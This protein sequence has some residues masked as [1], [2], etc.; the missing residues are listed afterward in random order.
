MN[1]KLT[2]ALDFLEEILAVEGETIQ[3]PART[4]QRHAQAILDYMRPRGV[5]LDRDPS[6]DVRSVTQKE[7]VRVVAEFLPDIQL[8]EHTDA[9]GTYP[10][11]I[12]A[13][14]KDKY[15]SAFNALLMC[16][17]VRTRKI[18]GT[19]QYVVFCK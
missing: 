17:G 11:V 15:S 4:M 6:G 12:F 16:K 3:A 10:A 18:D 13:E 9:D 14:G 5:A 19:N 7:F 8:T 1:E 2:A